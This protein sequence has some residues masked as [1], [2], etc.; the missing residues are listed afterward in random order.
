VLVI[1]LP[2]MGR[3]GMILRPDVFIAGLV[4]LLTSFASLASPPNPPAVTLAIALIPTLLSLL[5]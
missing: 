5:P 4:G 2:V 3:S 1:F